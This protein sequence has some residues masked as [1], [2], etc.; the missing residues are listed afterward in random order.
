[1]TVWGNC[2]FQRGSK[3]DLACRS[4]VETNRKQHVSLAHQGDAH[5]SRALSHFSFE[6]FEEY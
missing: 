3:P 6:G 2:D 4:R 1:M 5:L